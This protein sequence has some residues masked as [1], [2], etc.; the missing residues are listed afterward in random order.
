[1]MWEAIKQVLIR[2]CHYSQETDKYTNSLNVKDAGDTYET[3]FNKQAEQ[4]CIANLPE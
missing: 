4:H 3:L 1:M 2:Y